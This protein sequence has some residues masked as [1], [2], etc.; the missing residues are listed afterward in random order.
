MLHAYDPASGEFIQAFDGGAEEQ[1]RL[2]AAGLTVV[3]GG[4]GP[5]PKT[6][7]YLG[8]VLTPKV[9]VS[10]IPDKAVIAADGLDQALVAVAVAGESPPESIV[11][12]VDGV[13]AEVALTDGLGQLPPITSPAAHVFTVRA[14]DQITYQ[15]NGGCVV[16]AQEQE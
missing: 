15:D 8:G 14:A 2:Q 3:E 13:A 9:I 16:A 5:G 6:H 7:N 4:E 1:A 11:I 10:L 12:E